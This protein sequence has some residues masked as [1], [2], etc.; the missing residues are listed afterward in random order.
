VTQCEAARVEGHRELTARFCTL[1]LVVS[2]ESVGHYRKQ[3]L[4]V[5]TL[6]PSAMKLAISLLFALAAAVC[7]REGC[8]WVRG[9]VR[10]PLDPVHQFDVLIT[11]RD[12]DGLFFPGGHLIDGDDDFG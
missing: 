3:F 8:I 11:V 7:A 6:S 12:R 5:I 1:P 10:C 4:P 9:S 2:L